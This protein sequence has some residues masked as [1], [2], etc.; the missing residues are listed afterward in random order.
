M[1]TKSIF[2]P[3]VSISISHVFSARYEHM[4]LAIMDS[5]IIIETPRDGEVSIS[6]SHVFSARYEHMSL[7]IMDSHTPRVEVIGTCL[8]LGSD[9]L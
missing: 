1:S 8:Q 9:N 4:S 7:A 2:C 5:H 6:I 3:L